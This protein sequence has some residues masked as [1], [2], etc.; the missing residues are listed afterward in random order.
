V[1]L[2]PGADA[3]GIDIRV[4][5]VRAW[6]VRGVVLNGTSRQPMP[7]VNLQL[8]S[9][10]P[11]PRMLQTTSDAMG[12]YA[13]PKV[14]SG[15]YLLAGLAQQAGVGRLMP[16]EVRD[17]DVETTLE[18]QPF[19]SLTGRVVAPNPAAL[20]VRLRLDYGIPNPPQLNATPAAD[21]SFTLRN[22]PP[23]DYRVFVSPILQPQSPVPASIPSALQNTYVKAMRM[24]NADLLNGS[25]RL[26]RP[27]DGQI[28]ISL[29]TDSGSLSGRVL[30]G[31][32][33]PLPGATVV[34]LPDLD[35]RLLRTDLY[36]TANTDE[37]GR[38]LMEG[39][40]PGDYRVFSWEKVADF[41]WQDP[42]FMRDYEERGRAVHLTEK[43]R[44]TI[45]LT[46]I[47]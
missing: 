2:Q 25:L 29:A 38:F 5:P 34:L 8:I 3:R 31:R 26:D 23:G 22:V 28:E 41:A 15:P 20:T 4:A 24:G 12:R 1:E 9:M 40:P 30:D 18:L 17:S 42:A 13:I 10:G 36:K 46:I 27:P 7:G 11:S 6:R 43:A 47:P 14:A 45:D 21:G 32:Q 37:A 33:E 39:L 19:Y 16:L 35:R 44:E